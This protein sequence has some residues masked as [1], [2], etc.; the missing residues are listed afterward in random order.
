[1]SSNTIYTFESA[2]AHELGRDQ[3]SAFSDREKERIL[4]TKGDSQ[5]QKDV[6]DEL[7]FDPM[8]DSTNI[9]VTAKDGVV[10][11]TGT[12]PS[13]PEK[14]A[15]ER[16][17]KRVAGVHGI[18]EELKVDIPSMLHRTDADIVRAALVALDW[19]VTIPKDK[20][21]VKVEDGWLTLEGELGWQYQK[22]VV[23]RAVEHLI[24]VRGVTNAINLKPTVST[25]DVRAK[26]RQVFERAAE[27]DANQ[28]QVD[29]SD[30]VVTLRGSVHSWNEHDE[31][32]HAASSVPG[33]KSV[34]NYTD[35]K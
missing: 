29:I 7:A 10:T 16:A 5:L 32:A 22:D 14:V 27:I 26:I 9:G 34:R 15:A 28:V 12:V 25:G 24:G 4:M 18:A 33:V 6:I 19:N 21:T 2:M 23:R 31:A 1:M 20:V 3:A 30:G 35:V 11:L 8:V 13:Y 17:V